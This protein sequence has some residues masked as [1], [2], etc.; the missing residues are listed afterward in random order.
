[1]K[2]LCCLIEGDRLS[3]IILYI[4]AWIIIYIW[5]GFLSLRNQMEIL[6]VE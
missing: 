3:M 1:M 5:L 4:I 2:P 6:K